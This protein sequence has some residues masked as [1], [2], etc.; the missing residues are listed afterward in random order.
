MFAAFLCAVISVY[1]QKISSEKTTYLK[2]NALFL[3]LG[4]LNAGIETQLAPKYT[5]Q[6]DVFISPWKSFAGHEAQVYMLGLEG[7]YYFSEAFRHWYVGANI[8]ASRFIIQKWNYWK[9]RPYQFQQKEEN[10][11][12]NT[13]DLYQDGFAFH[14]GV[15]VGYQFELSENWNLDLYVGGGTSQ[16]FYK[17]YDRTTGLRYDNDG[18]TWNRSGELIPYRGGVMISYKIK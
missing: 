11:I 16:D 10:P 8:S 7:R 18:R 5:F 2:A 15:T 14:F 17:G 13:S 1:G 6:A 9:S 12:L 4:M 3:P